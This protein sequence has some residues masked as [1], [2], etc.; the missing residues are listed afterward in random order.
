VRGVFGSEILRFAQ[1]DRRQLADSARKRPALASSRVQNVAEP[2]DLVSFHRRK[3]PTPECGRGQMGSEI[4]PRQGAERS[5]PVVP[6]ILQPHPPSPTTRLSKAV[7]IHS[8]S[9][10]NQRHWPRS[11]R[12]GLPTQR[13]PSAGC[14][15]AG[16]TEPATFA[17]ALQWAWQ[18]TVPCCHLIG[19]SYGM[20]AFGSNVRDSPRGNSPVR[21]SVCSAS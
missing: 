6:T 21:P 19:R 4:V 14:D 10:A 7:A 8:V 3:L 12:R 1:D 5:P 20:Q 17:V 13:L 11:R 15:V 9:R 2:A 16:R 18:V